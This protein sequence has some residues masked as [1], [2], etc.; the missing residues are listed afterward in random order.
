MANFRVKPISNSVYLACFCCLPL[1][2][3]L[4]L[5]I[6]FSDN[7]HPFWLVDGVFFSYYYFGIPFLSAGILYI[8]GNNKLPCITNYNAIWG[9]GIGVFIWFEIL[10]V[11]LECRIESNP[12][13][14][15][16]EMIASVILQFIGGVLAILVGLVFAR[17]PSL[18]YRRVIYGG[19]VIFVIM[20]VI[21]TY[22][23][24]RNF[25]GYCY[26]TNTVFTDKEKIN[27]IIHDL[28]TNKN[29]PSYIKLPNGQSKEVYLQDYFS[30]EE[31]LIDNPNCCVILPQYAF[32]LNSWE[33]SFG[34]VMSYVAGSFSRHITMTYYLYYRDDLGVEHK[35][36]Y[37]DKRVINNCGQVKVMKNIKKT[38]LQ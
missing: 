6:L 26:S 3:G 32:Y 1:Y 30:T 29:Y 20:L 19:I 21:P 38:D 4:L 10:N 23:L 34:P 17:K 37:S 24:I 25:Q 31:F 8:L 7:R 12:L 36:A 27:L 5:R 28:I 2:I 15:F 22:T 9:Y 18:N 11:Y 13:D 16:A 35:Q 14:N 33:L